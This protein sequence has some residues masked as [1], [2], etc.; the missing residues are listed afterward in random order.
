MSNAVC[1][2]VGLDLGQVQDYTALAIIE[3]P[4]IAP[5]TPIADRLGMAVYSVRH[6]ERFPLGTSYPAIVR[7][8]VEIAKQLTPAGGKG[9]CIDSTGVGRPVVEML[10]AARPQIQL[11]PMTITAG[12]SHNVE[13]DFTHVPKKEL[14][15]VMQILLQERRLKIAESLPAAKVL[16]EELLAFK[17]KI[18]AA[19]NETFEAWR[20]RDH[21]DL[22]LAV[23]MPTWLA[24]HHRKRTPSPEE[25]QAQWGRIVS[26]V[27]PRIWQAVA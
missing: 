23:A 17:V 22:V 3:R 21:D 10:A 4:Y 24:E 25:W 16:M 5:T 12:N 26:P 1:C 27:P 20:E 15:S 8:V 13:G 6:L 11:F 14:V 9:L 19:A 18:T 2:Y 7:R